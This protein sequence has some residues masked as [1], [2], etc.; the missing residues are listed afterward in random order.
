LRLLEH[1]KL[2]ARTLRQD[3]VALYFAAKD[4][5]TPWYAKAVVICII[6]YALSPIDLIPDFIPVLGYV[7]DLLFLPLGIYIAIKIIPEPVLFDCRRRAGE[8]DG[9]LPRNWTAAATIVLLWIAAISAL[10]IYLW[11]VVG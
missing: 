1:I 9:S 11:R 7:D 6:A 4:Q 2:T 8:M 3:V 10:A 5:R